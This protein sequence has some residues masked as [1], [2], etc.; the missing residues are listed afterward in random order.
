[1]FPIR[2]QP[3]R[4]GSA[5]KHLAN[6]EV[7]TLGDDD[8]AH[9]HRIGANMMIGSGRQAAISHVLRNVTER[10]DLSG[11]R[12]WQLRVDQEAQSG[13]PQHQM[14]KGQRRLPTVCQAGIASGR[15]T[16]RRH[17]AFSS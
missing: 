2:T 16:V 8:R 13:A 12:R 17:T 7:F 9:V 6:D 15:Q 14:I 10:F 1:M 5:L 3:R 4:R 11:E